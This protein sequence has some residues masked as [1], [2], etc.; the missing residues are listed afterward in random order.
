MRE[1][2]ARRQTVK[3]S[4]DIPFLRRLLRGQLQGIENRS[5]DLR[6]NSQCS[7]ELSDNLEA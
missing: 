7:S 5:F 3:E 1:S 6:R 4:D 2:L